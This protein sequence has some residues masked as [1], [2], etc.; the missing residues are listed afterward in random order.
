MANYA[1]LKAAIQSVITTN[2]NNEITGAILQQ[3]LLSVIDSLGANSQFCGIATPATNPGTPDQNVAYIGGPGTYPNFNNSVVPDGYLGVFKYNG[4]WTFGTIQVGKNYDAEIN[5]E[6][7]RNGF[8]VEESAIVDFPV[9]FKAGEKWIFKNLTSTPYQLAI[10]RTAD[11]AASGRTIIPML[12][13]ATVEMTLEYDYVILSTL[14][15]VSKKFS[16]IQNPFILDLGDDIAENSERIDQLSYVNV[17]SNF[18]KIATLSGQY[19]SSTGAP[20]SGG[21]DFSIDVY[22]VN[23]KDILKITLSGGVGISYLWALYNGSTAAAVAAANL[24]SIGK[25]LSNSNGENTINVETDCILAI[26]KYVYATYSFEYT[27]GYYLPDS[28]ILLQDELHGLEYVNGLKPLSLLGRLDEQYIG[29]GGAPTTGGEDFSIDVYS[30]NAL[31]EI[32]I[33]LSGGAGGAYLWGLYSGTTI[34]DISA[35]NLLELGKR[36]NASN[37]TTK[38]NVSTNC[39]LA[40][41]KYRHAAY[42]VGLISKIM[43]VDRV[44]NVEKAMNMRYSLYSNILKVAFCYGNND[45]VVEMAPTG[46]N[47]LFDFVRFSTIEKDGELDVVPETLIMRAGTD[48]HAPF[49]VGAVNNIN[50]DNKTGDVYNENFTG[51]NHQYNNAASGST[52]TATLE[53]VRFYVN[54]QRV[55]QGNGRFQSLRVEWSNLVQAYNTTLAAGGGRAVLREKHTLEIINNKFVATVEI[56]PLE[57]IVMKKW[58]GLQYSGRTTVYTYS[59]YMGGVNRVVYTGESNSGN[60]KPNGIFAYGANHQLKLE[61]DITFDAG[62]RRFFNRTDDGAF[63]TTSKGYLYIINDT[64]FA[65]DEHIFLRGSWTFEPNL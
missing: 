22:S 51:G 60:A 23:T 56:I 52:P 36:L 5:T 54:G 26:T 6:K 64:N 63:C 48:W 41:T 25:K 4:T 59:V 43:L 9:A 28:I 57:P 17:P 47:G 11:K 46:G 3:T 10:Y 34:N 29:T 55:T 44:N 42:S 21:G 31:D 39:L 35:G 15:A 30:V 19:I 32:Q 37:G 27:K 20:A 14:A 18:V 50:G 53:Y 8:I 62:D 45:M 38:I 16:I 2:G 1:T 58:Y 24:L 40:I 13:N 61:C 33:I 49:I 12:A 65:Q 7:F